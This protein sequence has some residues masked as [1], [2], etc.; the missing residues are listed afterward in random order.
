MDLDADAGHAPLCRMFADPN[1][2]GKMWYKDARVIVL[3]TDSPTP[4]I[5]FMWPEFC[6]CAYWVSTST[7]H[8]QKPH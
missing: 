7:Y 1:Y 6:S 8:V 5:E 2:N 4:D 3:K